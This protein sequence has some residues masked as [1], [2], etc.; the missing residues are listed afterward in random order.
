[1]ATSARVLA[2]LCIAALVSGCAGFGGSR[3][4]R[5]DQ[6]VEL[7]DVPFH[8]QVTD[9]CGPA[10]LATVLN[11]SGIE[12]G[13]DSLRSRIYIPGRQGSLQVELLAATRQHGRVPY[14]TDASVG[15]L[16]DELYAG[17]PV[18]I[19]QN[20]GP[21]LAPV[22]H[23]AVVVG[24]LPERREFV[25]RSADRERH[26]LGAR[27][28][29]GSWQRAGSWAFVALPPGSL[30]ADGDADRYLAAAAA[31][32]SV[33]APAAAAEVYRVAASR[34]PNEGIAWLG[35]GNASYT[36]GDLPGARKAYRHALD[37]EP[38]NLAALNNWSQVQAE[39]GCR[40]AAI[41]AIEAA[42][43]DSTADAP[44]YGT[45]LRTRDEIANMEPVAACL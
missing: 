34:W 13:P 19:L 24:Y 1:M 11:Y 33:A 10:A 3:L 18:L 9:Q 26:V 4:D 29:L 42:L 43:A 31:F 8:P 21:R 45:L 15:A 37:A 36:A 39:L 6:P 27:A 7:V 38:G 44:L 41:T 16:I 5:Y 14:P 25:L 35:L 12:I 30:P 20:L 17:R 28:F 2:V 22:W 23:Y 32:E 40:D